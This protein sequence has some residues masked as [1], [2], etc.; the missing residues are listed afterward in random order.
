M[1]K[2]QIEVD[3]PDGDYCMD[4]KV[5]CQYMGDACFSAGCCGLITEE[6]RILHWKDDKDKSSC[7]LQY[8]RILKHPKCPSLLP[9]KE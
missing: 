6:D 3:I 4:D 8:E 2:Y 9:R 5:F 1:S 7:Q